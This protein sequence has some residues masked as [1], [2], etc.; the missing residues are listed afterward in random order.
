[1]VKIP[2]SRRIRNLQQHLADTSGAAILSHINP[3]GDSIGSSLALHLALKRNGL[4]SSVIVP[5]DVPGFLSW[6]PGAGDMII[7]NRET[8]LALARIR[9]AGTIFIIDFNDTGRLDLLEDE[10]LKNKR[11]LKVLI[12]HHPNPVV[13]AEVIYSDV[14]ASSTAELI[15][16]FLKEL[17]PEMKMTREIAENL[18]TGIMTDTGGFSHNLRSYET[19]EVAADLIRLGANHDRIHH[20]VYSTFTESRMRL[21][22]FALHE[23]MKILEDLHTGYIWLTRDDLKAFRHVPGDTEGFVNLPLSIR[24]VRCSALFI[25]KRDHIKISFRSRGDFAVN[26]FSARYFNGGGHRNAAGG[27]SNASLAETLK[28]F[29][30]RIREHATEI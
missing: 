10:T 3:D 18:Y 20:E 17:F 19:L 2:D 23:R 30:Q 22:G 8:E 4:D 1:M 9:N 28:M 16:F 24:D 15:Y 12:D 14:T 21:M 7:A 27:N 11:A 29:E 13:P 26:E 5:N 6:L 25:E